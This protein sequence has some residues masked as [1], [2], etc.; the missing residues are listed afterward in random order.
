MS[1]G[2]FEK[3]YRS[4]KRL[5]GSDI[6]AAKEIYYIH[7]QMQQEELLIQASGVAV[8]A[9]MFTR[10]IECF[11]IPRIRRATQA[12]GIVMIAQQMCGS[13]LTF[14]ASIANSD[15]SQSTSSPSTH[16]LFSPRLVLLSREPSWHPGA[17]VSSTSCSPGPQSGPSIPSADA[18]CCSL[19]SLICAGPC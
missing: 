3:A 6:R 10:F 7:A 1:K 17:S 18:P 12:S 2:R 5:R 4:L 14:S 19:P 9:N 16:P 15:H 13:R 8:H 11:T